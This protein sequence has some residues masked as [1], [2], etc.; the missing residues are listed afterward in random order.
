MDNFW[1]DLPKPFSALAPME[2]VTDIVFR[3]TVAQAARPDIFFTEFVN[4]T[5]FCNPKGRHSTRGRLEFDETEQPIVAQIWGNKP[6]EFAQISTSL[7]SAG[8]AGIDINMGC[9][10]KAVVKQGSGSAL[11]QTPDL[12]CQIIASAKTGGLPV[13]VKTRIGNIKPDEWHD[14]IKLLL[15]QD[16]VNLT[17]HLRTRKEASKVPAHYELIPEIVRLRNEVAPNTLI[18]I[19]GDIASYHDGIEL[20]NKYG[21]EGFMIGRGIFANP[22]AFEKNPKTHPKEE[23]INLLKLQLDLHDKY[24]IDQTTRKFDPLK[25]YFKIY[26]R[27][28]PGASELRE[29]LMHTKNTNEARA[30]IK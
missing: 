12:A 7:V 1:L 27:D 11:I 10:D 23:L 6:D 8:F 19:N 25:R 28:F 20:A 18:T 21:F 29:K 13:S 22:F 14:W 26:I 2:A 3:K 24:N 5:S 9:P 15:Q 17:I 30:L 4:V 16:I